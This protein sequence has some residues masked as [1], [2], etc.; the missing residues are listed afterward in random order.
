[1]RSLRE[2]AVLVAGLLVAS[3][4]LAQAPLPPAGDTVPPAPG[5]FPS[6][7]QPDGS[8]RPASDDDPKASIPSVLRGSGSKAGGPANELNPSGRPETPV[9]P[10]GD[11]AG[12]LSKREL[13][14]GNY[15][16]AGQRAE[17]LPPTDALDAAC[18]RHDACFDAAGHPSC[19]CNKT[20]MREAA[21]VAD[22]RSLTPEVRRRA[23][24]VVQA[25][26]LMECQAP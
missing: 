20:L 16:G 14:H 3:A 22:D 8:A 5:L 17:G 13:F 21:A 11:L 12:V 19:E 10:K 6:S 25:A 26:D 1:M 23:L 7:P 4:A 2:L 24:S 18:Q 15:C 9:G